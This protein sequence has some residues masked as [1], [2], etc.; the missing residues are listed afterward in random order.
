MEV[1]YLWASGVNFVDITVK[2]KI[3]EGNI[4]RSIISINDVLRN[5][6]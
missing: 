2:T 1:A 5:I 3:R 6:H 4:V